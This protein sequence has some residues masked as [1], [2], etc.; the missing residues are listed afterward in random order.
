[1][2]NLWARVTLKECSF[3]QYCK[4]P[5]NG[6][7]KVGVEKGEKTGMLKRGNSWLCVARSEGE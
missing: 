6:N 2:A 5:E 3:E 7:E 1:M 4:K